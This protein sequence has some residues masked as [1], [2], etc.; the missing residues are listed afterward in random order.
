MTAAG[1]GKIMLIIII[2]CYLLFLIYY[3]LL[4]AIENISSGEQPINI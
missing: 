4:H 3:L 2:F 1:N